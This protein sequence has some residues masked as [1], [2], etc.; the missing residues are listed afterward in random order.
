MWANDP[1][2]RRAQHV[3]WATPAMRRSK[4]R[5]PGVEASGV[6]AAHRPARCGQ[7]VRH[8][9]RRADYPERTYLPTYGNPVTLTGVDELVVVPSPS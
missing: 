3:L 8:P 4:L 5:N 2:S 7:R 6:L 9:A 1:P